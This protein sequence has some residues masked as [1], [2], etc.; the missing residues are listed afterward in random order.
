MPFRKRAVLMGLAALA[1]AAVSAWAQDWS[2]KAVTE[3]GAF[4][5]IWGTAKTNFVSAA[6]IQG[7]AAERVTVLKPSKPWDAGTYAPITKPVHKGDIVA[8]MFRARAQTPPAGSDLIMVTGSVYE[9]GSSGTP[10]TP[11]ATFVIGRQWKLYVVTGK[12]ERDY[13]PGTLSAGMK[14]GTG[15]QTIDFG[16]IYVLDLGPDFDP[17]MLPRE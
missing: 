2:Q 14:L 3:P 5:S 16:P 17:N 10:I 4:W 1:S 6:A 11:E 9:A 7:G 12:A 15:D 13:P 8:L